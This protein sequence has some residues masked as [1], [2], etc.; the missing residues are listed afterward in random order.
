VVISVHQGYPNDVKYTRSLGKYLDVRE[1]QDPEAFSLEVGGSSLVTGTFS[2]FLV[3]TPVYLDDQSLLTQM[4]S[5]IKG[6]T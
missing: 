3:L 5:T 6:P 1:S 2:F 4:K